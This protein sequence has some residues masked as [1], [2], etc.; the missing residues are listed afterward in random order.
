MPVLL[1]SIPK[2]LPLLLLSAVLLAGCAARIPDR[3][4]S[5]DPEVHATARQAM[6]SAAPAVQ[7]R[8]LS[9]APVAL[10]DRPVINSP[11]LQRALHD[12][13]GRVVAG[14]TETSPS[15]PIE[16]FVLADRSYGASAI[17]G[18][19]I[20]VNL[21]VLIAAEYEDEIAFVLGHESGH[22]L[23]GHLME[24][25]RWQGGAQ[26]AI[27]LAADGVSYG[28]MLSKTRVTASA[29]SGVRTSTNL[30][31]ADRDVITAA[32]SGMRLASTLTQELGDA[33]FSRGQETQA[34]QF[35]LDRAIKAGYSAEGAASF[36]K[37]LA[38]SEKQREQEAAVL[39]G[40]M[41]QSVQLATTIA[42]R[43][44]RDPTGG[45]LGKAVPIV[46]LGF[47][48]AFSQ[49]VS[50]LTERYFSLE[51]RRTALHDYEVKHWPQAVET[52]PRPSPFRTGSLGREVAELARGVAAY[53]EV[54]LSLS[55]QDLPTAAR[56]AET[57][58]LNRL[59]VLR[60]M[61]R[62]H[63]AQARGQT[64]EALREAARARTA[65][66]A[67]PGAY[68]LEAELLN[69]M[70]QH[71]QAIQILEEGETRFG[72]REPFLVA[73][74]GTF[75][76]A[77][78]TTA[79]QQAQQECDA[80]GDAT[81]GRACYVASRHGSEDKPQRFVPPST[82]PPNLL[83]DPMKSLRQLWR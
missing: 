76:L 25:R 44:V 70:G 81:I 35:G 47:E 61:A 15:P 42:T 6:A 29:G 68:T 32:A 28:T 12:I 20:F 3:R 52:E 79:M 65:P 1:S 4:V 77:G 45:L 23:L 9:G 51:T 13:L 19:Q 74:A 7:G 5:E 71:G 36:F 50:P 53:D 60:A 83:S 78:N 54:D 49:A 38:A 57:P 43:G 63:V 55:R 69:Q 62:A 30:D 40:S 80:T 24:R 10:A 2:A 48:K 18:N 8:S 73:R 56:A 26:R 75:A 59:P 27:G 66:E 64:A 67:T 16:I 22:V 46:S 31:Q 11:A 34:D 33:L 37:V 41:N 17:P 39:R 58:S 82:S 21:G 72:T 14:W